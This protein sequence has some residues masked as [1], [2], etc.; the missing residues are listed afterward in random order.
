MKKDR[1]L[2]SII[3]TTV[4]PATTE[5]FVASDKFIINT[6]DGAPVKIAFMN[7]EF[8]EWFGNKVENP[9]P[10]SILRGRDLL[11]DDLHICQ[12]SEMLGRRRKTVIT[13][14]EVYHSMCCHATHSDDSSVRPGKIFQA[15]DV[16]G[17]PRTIYVRRICNKFVI[18]AHKADEYLL[19]TINYRVLSHKDL[20]AVA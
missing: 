20:A 8:I 17:V 7:D 4:V 9:F 11:Q 6:Q 16:N 15:L 10:G 2:S 13:L 12:I 14:T 5:P 19:G 18:R 3:G 1:V